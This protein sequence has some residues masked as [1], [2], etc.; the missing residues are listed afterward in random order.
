M[1]HVSS[2]SPP[3]C[4][5]PFPLIEVHWEGSNHPDKE[6]CDSHLLIMVRMLIRVVTKR[7]KPLGH[8]SLPRSFLRP[9][10]RTDRSDHSK[11]TLFLLDLLELT[12]TREC[13]LL[14]MISRLFL[15]VSKIFLTVIFSGIS[16]NLFGILKPQHSWNKRLVLI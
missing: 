4:G 5:V 14:G 13:I 15:T 9:Y 6:E 1:Q 16:N 12:T 3:V 8:P 7:G 10:H 2:N 11:Q